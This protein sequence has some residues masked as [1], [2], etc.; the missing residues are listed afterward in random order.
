[1]PYWPAPLFLLRH[2]SDCAVFL[3]IW[4]P[5]DIPIS[6]AI[7]AVFLGALIFFVIEYIL[8]MACMVSVVLQFC[9]CIV[10]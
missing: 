8:Q 9:L 3:I 5:L 2:V 10:H 7:G 6:A 1:M 4:C